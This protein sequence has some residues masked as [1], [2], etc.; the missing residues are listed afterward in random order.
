MKDN[1]ASHRHINGKLAALT[2]FAAGLWLLLLLTAMPA[3]A[4]ETVPVLGLEVSETAQGS[5]TI[6]EQLQLFVDC[7]G[8]EAD[9]EDCLHGLGGGD[10]GSLGIALSPDGSLLASVVSEGDNTLSLWRVDAQGTLS[11]SALYCAPGAG[12]SCEGG[13]EVEHGLGEPNDVV[14]SFDGRLLF[15]TERSLASLSVWRVDA[16][17][18]ALTRTA[19]YWDSG[20]AGRDN[21]LAAN[22][23]SG[24]DGDRRCTTATVLGVRVGL[25]E[26]GGLLADGLFAAFNVAVSPVAGHDLLFVTG[27]GDSALSV[28]RINTQAGTLTQT[29]LY[30]SGSCSGNSGANCVAGESGLASARGVAVSRD[31]LVFTTGF[32]DDALKIWRLDPDVSG[33]GIL[34]PTGLYVDGEDGITGLDGPRNVAVSPNGRLVFTAAAAA[35]ALSVWQVNASP[36]TPTL[37]QSAVYADTGTESCTSALENAGRCFDGLLAVRNLALSPDGGLLFVTARSNDDALSAWEVDYSDGTLTQ[38]ALIEEGDDPDAIAGL[39]TASSIAVTESNIVFVSAGGAGDALS[40]W[41]LIP[42]VPAYSTVQLTVTAT[43]GASMPIAATVTARQNELIVMVPVTLASTSQVAEFPAGAL[44]PGLWD[45]SVLAEPGVAELTAARAAL[46]VAQLSLRLLREQRDEQVHL[47]ATTLEGPPQTTVTITVTAVQGETTAATTFLLT[48]ELYQDVPAAFDVNS[49]PPGTYD[50]VLSAEPGGIV[51]ILSRR[52]DLV[53]RLPTVN[54]VTEQRENQVHLLATTP[55]GP[56]AEDVTVTVEA[57]QGAT[58]ITMT[59][60]LLTPESYQDVQA[61]FDVNSLPSGTYDLVL[62]AV[63]SGIVAIP[64]TIALVVAPL[65]L[66]LVTD[67]VGRQLDIT[68]SS[69]AAPLETVTVT[70]GLRLDGTPQGT[71]LQITLSPGN[72]ENVTGMVSLGSLPGGS[73]LLSTVSSPSGIVMDIT[74]RMLTVVPLLRFAVAEILPEGVEVEV[75]VTVESALAATADVTVVAH[76]DSLPPQMVNADAVL[77]FPPNSGAPSSMTAVFTAGN[78]AVGSWDFRAELDPPGVLLLDNSVPARLSIAPLVPVTLAL[79]SPAQSEVRKGTAISLNLAVQGAG[80]DAFFGDVVITVVA[81]GMSGAGSG[82]MRMES[83]TLSSVVRTATVLFTDLASGTWGFAVPDA[84]DTVEVTSAAE[85]SVVLPT[86]TLEPAVPLVDVDGDMR[87]R[88][89]VGSP[90]RVQVTADSA[91]DAEVTLTVTAT[92]ADDGTTIMATVVLSSTMTAGTA[93]FA[94]ANALTAQ[95]WTFSAEAN[96]PDTVAF[97]AAAVDPVTVLLPTISLAAQSD[98][99]PV[100]LPVNLTVTASPLAPGAEVTVTVLAASPGK[101][102]VSATA[103]LSPLAPSAPAVFEAGML[104]QGDWTFS[105]TAAPAGFADVSAATAAVTVRLPAVRLIRAASTVVA[106]NTVTLTVSADAPAGMDTEITVRGELMGAENTSASAT[107]RLSMDASSAEADFLMLGE[108]EWAFTIEAATPPGIVDIAAAEAVTVT[109]AASVRVLRSVSL[110]P[111]QIV[112]GAA[113]TLEVVRA[114]ADSSTLTLSVLRDGTQETSLVIP[115]DETLATVTVSGDGIGAYTY[116]LQETGGENAL[117]NEG[118]FSLPLRV[119]ADVQLSL[120]PAATARIQQEV[121]IRATLVNAS[122]TPLAPN[123]APSLISGLSVMLRIMH[124]D[125][126]LDMTLAFQQASLAAGGMA[127]FGEVMFTPTAQG[128]WTV[129]ASSIA[130]VDALLVTV[131]EIAAATLIVSGV[132]LTLEPAVSEV[133]IGSTVQVTVAGGSLLS[134]VS[135]TALIVTAMQDG[136]ESVSVRLSELG[137]QV[138]AV[139]L[140]GQGDWTFSLTS[141]PE[142]LASA[143]TVTVTVQAADL[144]FSV[145]ESTTD[146]D[147]LVLALRYLT[148]CTGAD[149]SACPSVRT[150][151]LANLSGG[152]SDYNLAQLDTLAVPDVSGDG[153]GEIQDIVILLDYLAGVRDAEI[154]L[155]SVPAAER[156]QRMRIISQVLELVSP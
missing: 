87:R 13:T 32:S 36:S 153:E 31:G 77:R 75:V 63:P 119:V 140:L 76:M 96:V 88:A 91:P 45:F 152:A 68:L 135:V 24:R 145:P 18:A 148:L 112:Q 98:S 62:S 126:E 90:V 8:T 80:L 42:M 48:P 108:G 37:T 78:L 128:T 109:V 156:A 130:P 82:M 139:F 127:I 155:V 86:V 115:S 97:S 100:T 104:E 74:D 105:A 92:G 81:T 9:S 25:V 54:L 146:A 150:D 131:P 95:S 26:N 66:N 19:T 103:T 47:L 58:T 61:A 89:A 23:E 72:F 4:Q 147:D 14:F 122:G 110:M 134:S 3:G 35:H 27:R 33:T 70:V 46:R 28:W 43:P 10:D 71:T 117:D 133:L 20:N 106:G 1:N 120:A 2:K 55:E 41:S 142:D 116:S 149:I 121:V 129:T 125:T 39:E 99:V 64:S 151:L 15:V 53:V 5:S 67:Q 111:A 79:A 17:A 16:E 21:C 6:L 114:A 94:G 102:N 83:A 73:Y 118:E 107:V 65:S 132:A 60:F 59:T 138:Q 12:E 69:G 50:L 30:K 123:L 56:P 143:P 101:A 34:T 137:P 85:I 57:V 154:L 7:A 11:R 113:A 51:N 52:A 49:L 22:P 141:E 29:A 144:D 93:V 40:A 38:V 136:E 84:P 44:L 124:Q